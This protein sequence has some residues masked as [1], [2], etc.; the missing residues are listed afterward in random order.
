MDAIKPPVETVSIR[1]QDD[2]DIDGRLWMPSDANVPAV[3]QILH[4]LGEHADRYHRF[5]LAANERGYAVMS[6][7]HRGH[8]ALA[9]Q[10][11]SFGA[12]DGFRLLEADVVA[13]RDDIDRRFDGKPVILLGHSMGSFLAQHYA[14][15]HGAKLRGMILSGSGWPSRLSLT[16]GFVLAWITSK[17]T[18]RNKPSPMLDKLGFD[19]L[20]KR[21]E[22][23]RT[24]FDW[25]SRDTAEVDRY[26]EDPLCGGPY[27]AGLWVDFLGGL[28]RVTSDRALNRIPAELPILIAGGANDPVGGDDGLGKLMLHYAQTLH[29]RLTLKLYP[30]GRHEML[31]EINRDEVTADWLDWVDRLVKRQPK[32]LKEDIR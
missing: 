4:G 17:S 11:G 18:G 16:P 13:V 21:F 10:R 9:E 30:E 23:A 31:N 8:G 20:N 1:S 12:K 7:N 22:P 28:L 24:P 27:T 14:L 6:H 19:S 25:L 26:I 15:H 3:I 29:S 2:K 5:A 32:S